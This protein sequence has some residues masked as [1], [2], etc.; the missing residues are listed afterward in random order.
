VLLAVILCGNQ[1]QGLVFYY[2]L[3]HRR[4]CGH[5]LA[6]KL[7][8]DMGIAQAFEEGRALELSWTLDMIR[9]YGEKAEQLISEKLRDIQGRL[10][11]KDVEKMV[12]A[13]E[14]ADR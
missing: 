13:L 12:E 8:V 4:D 14:N 11:K 10:I 5:L 7:E 3:A 2:S 6:G 9:L 1:R